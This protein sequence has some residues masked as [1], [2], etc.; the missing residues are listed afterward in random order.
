MVTALVTL[1]LLLGFVGFAML[2]QATSGVG[3]VALGCLVAILARIAQ[4]SEYQKAETKRRVAA[5]Q[6]AAP[7]PV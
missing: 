6:A 7:P 2:S 5:D 3:A 1:S 4:A